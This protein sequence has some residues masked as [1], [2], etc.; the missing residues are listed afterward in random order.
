MPT[1]RLLQA[2]AKRLATALVLLAPLNAPAASLDID[3]DG[4]ILAD[5]DGA[6][7]LRHLFGYTGAT[8]VD[9]VVGANA[10]RD[11]GA[12]QDYLN[13]L[14]SALD[15]DGDARVDALTDGLLLL[16]WMH[17]RTGEALIAGVLSPT[18]TRQTADAIADYIESIRAPLA[19]NRAL[20]GPLS[21]AA[22]HAYRL[23]DLANPVEGPIEAAASDT[24][25]ALAGTF[26]L[27]LADIPDDEWVLVTASGG[28]DIDAD[29][30]G[31]PDQA[32]TPNAG[33]LHAL[34]KA[35]DWRAGGLTVTPLS[36][37]FWRYTENLVGQVH[38][39]EVSL[40]LHDLL[41]L[42][43]AGDVDGS[44]G[45]NVLD[46]LR[47]LPSSSAHRAALNFDYGSLQTV[48]DAG[49]SVIAALRQGDTAALSE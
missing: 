9:G 15:L 20:L 11:A 46:P 34:A 6:L 31:V 18:A 44:G 32:P 17:G 27:T 19:T 3:G 38:P 13:G 23:D 22:I 14:G 29:Q 16:R 36:D 4:A 42:F 2:T 5:T 49:V 45:V 7:I 21:G 37:L 39:D 33:T 47:F 48:G 25:L 26:A 28:E 12:I 1:I 30:D 10:E 35:G 40:R 24:D 41:D 43:V 8:L